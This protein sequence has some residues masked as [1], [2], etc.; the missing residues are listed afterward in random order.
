MEKTDIVILC[1]G[2]GT[3]LRKVVSDVPKPLVDINGRPFLDI[4]LSWINKNNHIGNVII[5]AGYMGEKIK[6]KYRSH[7]FKYNLKT[8]IEDKPLGTGG[9]VRNALEHIK[10]KNFVVLNGD[11]FINE[12]LDSIINFHNSENSTASIV[13]KYSDEVERYGLVSLDKSKKKSY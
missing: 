9:A 5:A 1:G 6:N 7:K 2:L 3:R 11:S 12:S 8:I 4:L 10:S 13:I